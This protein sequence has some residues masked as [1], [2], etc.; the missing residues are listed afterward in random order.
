MYNIQSD[1]YNIQSDMYNIQSGMYN[2]Q[3]DMFNI[4][5]DMS[6]RFRFFLADLED[7]KKFFNHIFMPV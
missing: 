4:Q 2:I 1:M 7:T 6:E 3:S 5:S